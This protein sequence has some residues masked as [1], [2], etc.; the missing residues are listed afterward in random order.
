MKKILSLLMGLT[1]CFS[2]LSISASAYETVSAGGSSLN[3]VRVPMDGTVIGE[4]MTAY[5]SV[6]HDISASEFIN[7]AA[8][9][10]K[11]VVAAVNGLFFNSYYSDSNITFPD[12]CPLILTN[13]VQNGEVLAGGGEHNALILTQDGKA[14]I[15]RVDITPQ[16]YVN[17]NGPANIWTVNGK[18][19]NSEAIIKITDEMTLP[20]TVGS[21]ATAY[22]IQNGMV[23]TTYSEGQS[24]TLQS[25]QAL[26]VFNAGSRSS[27]SAWGMVPSVGSS[28]EFKP[29]ISYSG[30]SLSGSGVDIVGGG[31]MLIHNGQNVNGNSSYNA[32][33][34]AD[35]KQNATSVL[36]R[37][38]VATMSDGSVVLGTGTA[39][40]AQIASYL[41]SIGATN[42]MSLDG[43]ASS[44]L[45]ENGSFV[46]SA[47]RELASVLVFTKT[48]AIPTSSDVYVNGELVK[49]PTYNVSGNNYVKLR[50]L[51]YVLDGTEKQ[52]AVNWVASQNM[53]SIMPNSE[54]ST[55]GGEMASL[56]QG[57]PSSFALSNSQL[58]FNSEIVSP[59]AYNINGNNFIKLRDLAE[60]IDFS[61]VW[62]ESIGAVI[63]DT[64]GTYKQ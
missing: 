35:P 62:D 32:S 45:Y 26:L 54:Y 44:M 6:N 30:G 42:A 43:G 22:L 16:A 61:L 52:F 3:I 53:V 55:V 13:L 29:S 28:V 14:I 12:N 50:D 63:V 46:T 56:A 60:I 20:Y 7:T 15:D 39:S 58:E 21:G 10:G 19:E 34:D 48:A 59:T 4:V 25:G 9:S 1:L 17:G 37:S 18:N 47:G 5:G 27:H 11:N 33:L 40:F 41:Q 8:G 51:A 23:S 57:A 36:Q 38:F 49:F 2:A 24:V 64:D 31:R